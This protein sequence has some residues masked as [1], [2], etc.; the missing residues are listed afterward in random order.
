MKALTDYIAVGQYQPYKFPELKDGRVPFETAAIINEIGESIKKILK[1]QLIKEPAR[2]GVYR[3]SMLGR[4][5]WLSIYEKFHE[6]VEFQPSCLQKAMHLEGLFFEEELYYIL[7]TLGY[8]NIN[9]QCTVKY[10]HAHLEFSG[11]PDFIVEHP[12]DGKTIIECKAVSD[13]RWKRMQKDG[14]GRQYDLQLQF[15]YDRVQPDN[16]LWVVRNRD[17]KEIMWIPFEYNP[18]ALAL[19][20]VYMEHFDKL[21]TYEDAFRTFEVQEPIRHNASKYRYVPYWYYVAKGQL[22]PVVNDLYKVTTNER[23]TY[24]VTGYNFPDAVKEYEPE[25][26]HW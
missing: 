1:D 18:A 26:S 5:I 6:G 19:S 4:D 14:P 11:H 17:T 13:K 24:V 21:E 8:T 7:T 3:A 23:N 12:T 10:T 16:A 9:R 22:H 2:T 25:T 20:Y 15:Y